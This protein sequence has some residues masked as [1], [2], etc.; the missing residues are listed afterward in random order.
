[1]GRGSRTIGW[2][3]C[4]LGSCLASCRAWGRPKRIG[5]ERFCSG[6]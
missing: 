3:R 4:H 2:H 1:M 5:S 6:I